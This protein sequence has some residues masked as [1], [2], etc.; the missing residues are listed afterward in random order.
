MTTS[1]TTTSES[2][3]LAELAIDNKTPI[4]VAIAEYVGSLIHRHPDAPY[5]FGKVK[6]DTSS[7][8]W[9]VLVWGQSTEDMGTQWLSLAPIWYISDWSTVS[10]SG[11]QFVEKKTA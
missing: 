8:I 11:G 7:Q 3:S 9:E 1:E 5:I 2:K 6:Q 4:A 10:A